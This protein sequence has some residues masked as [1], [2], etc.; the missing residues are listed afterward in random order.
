[1]IFKAADGIRG[2]LLDLDTGEVIPKVVWFNDQDGTFEAFKVDQRGEVLRGHDGGAVVWWGKGNLRF[3]QD[4]QPGKVLAPRKPKSFP[5]EKAPRQKVRQKHRRLSVK[6]FNADCE[7]YA[8]LR[9]AEY[10]VS[11]EMDLPPLVAGGRR[12]ARAKTL[13]VHYFCA[14]HYQPPR[15]LDGR[16]EVMSEW[17]E[18]GGVRPQ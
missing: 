10:A 1:M 11:D 15:I 13:K 7:H 2:K 12:W 18:A 14:F 17:E 16:G 5:S 9:P 8:C 6:L 3:V 4:A